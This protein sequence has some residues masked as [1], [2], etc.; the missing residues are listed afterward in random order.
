MAINKLILF[1]KAYDFLLWLFPLINRLPK[2][3]RPVLGRQIEEL[4]IR[5]LLD[6][7]AANSM[8]GAKRKEMQE[9]ISTE[10]DKLRILV[11]LTK[12]LKFM[13]V[14]QYTFASQRINELGSVLSGWMRAGQ[15]QKVEKKDVNMTLFKMG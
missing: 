9:L 15:P 14:K 6:I 11:R 8:R 4:G 12:D 13:S 5:I 7:I 1:Q 2:H 10:I 3:H